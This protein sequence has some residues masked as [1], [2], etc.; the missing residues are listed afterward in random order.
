MSQ[1]TVKELLKNNFNYELIEDV[2]IVKNTHERY[3]NIIPPE[4]VI[5]IKLLD[6]ICFPP[7]YEQSTKEYRFWWPE[8]NDVFY[9]PPHICAAMQD[10]L[11]K[12]GLFHEPLWCEIDDK[13]ST[14]DYEKSYEKLSFSLFEKT[15]LELSKTQRS[16]LFGRIWRNL[17][18]SGDDVVN[19][20]ENFVL[21]NKRFPFRSEKIYKTLEYAN[22]IGLLSEEQLNKIEELRNNC[23]KEHSQLCLQQLHDFCQRN[24]R[25]PYH[26]EK[27]LIQC[28]KHIYRYWRYDWYNEQEMQLIDNLFKTYANNESKGELAVNS[29]LTKLGY[30][31]KKQF[32]FDDCKDKRK[33]PFDSMFHIDNRI[34]LIEFDGEQHYKAVDHFGGEEHLRYIQNH[35]KI[36]NEYCLKNNIPLLRIRY[37]EIDKIEKLIDRFVESVNL[38]IGTELF[39]EE[40]EK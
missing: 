29:Y 35:D 3:I 31:V 16:F 38:A 24:K 15:P 33:L 1:N 21:T 11:R 13:I 25:W 40:I 14:Q 20:L 12:V 17:L 32:T 7:D 26:S 9:V 2:S 10:D 28:I 8:N 23:R 37:D 39:A 22:N 6:G 30:D 19:H 27:A 36:K 5:S 4:A 34:C 18:S